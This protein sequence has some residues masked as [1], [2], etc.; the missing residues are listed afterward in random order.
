MKEEKSKSKKRLYYILL[1]VVVLL[2]AAATVLTVFFVTGSG[3]EVLEKPDDNP[4]VEQ[5]PKEDDKPTT[6]PDDKPTTGDDVV[7]FTAPVAGGRY[8]ME[9]NAVYA[10]SALGWWY[11]HTA[12]DFAA[13]EGESVVAMSDGKIK[14]ISLCENTGNYILID[15]GNGL[16]SYYRFVEPVENLK[17]GDTVKSGA[18]IATVAKAYGS[19]SGEGTHLHLEVL[20]D[21]KNV[22]PTGYFD[23]VLEEK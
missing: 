16:E 21:G 4:P 19:E 17:V 20:K 7:V 14:E 15:H 1:A 3:N 22:D 9:Y 12:L 10:N 18:K 11:R 23:A 8:T 6:P 2:L 5:P 13:A